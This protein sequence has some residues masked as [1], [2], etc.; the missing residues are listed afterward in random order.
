MRSKGI[1]HGMRSKGI[2]EP[3]VWGVREYWSP[4]YEE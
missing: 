3:T 4:R 1:L 2:L